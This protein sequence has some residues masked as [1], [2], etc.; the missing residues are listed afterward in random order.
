MRRQTEKSEIFFLL[1]FVVTFLTVFT[2]SS[3][4]S[5]VGYFSC[6][7]RWERAWEKCFEDRMQSGYRMSCYPLPGRYHPSC[8]P[9]DRYLEFHEGGESGYTEMQRNRERFKREQERDRRTRISDVSF[10]VAGYQ[11]DFSRKAVSI[12]ATVMNKRLGENLRSV[13]LHCTVAANGRVVIHDGRARVETNLLPFS[14]ETFPIEFLDYEASSIGFF[15]GHSGSE[16]WRK[17]LDSPIEMQFATA[18]CEV[19]DAKYPFRF[20]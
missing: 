20:Q 18:S 11:K 10:S 15:G 16:K 13:D 4:L 12:Y 17:T 5:F 9:S 2:P 19:T 6:D 1:F 14:P 3:A 7:A 8:E